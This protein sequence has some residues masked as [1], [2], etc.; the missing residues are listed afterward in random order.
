[1]ALPGEQVAIE[2]RLLRAAEFAGEDDP[3]FTIAQRM[4]SQGVSA[5]AVAVMR[6]GETHWQGFYGADSGGP[7]TLFQAAS[8][9]KAVASVGIAALAR[10]RGFSLDADIMPALAGLLDP[11]AVNPGGVKVTLRG[12]LSHTNG[13]SVSG[14]PGYAEGETVPTTLGVVLG[15]GGS[16]TGPVIIDPAQIG[17]FNYS[18]GGYTLAQ[19]WAETVS[20]ESFAALM[21]RLV[22]RPIG[23]AH[24]S[25]ALQPPAADV[26]R[27]Q[28]G[29]DGP[30]PGGWNSYPE[31]AAAGL[32]TTPA[33]YGRFAHALMRA[34]KGDGSAGI[35]PAVAA[36]VLR[37]VEDDYGLGVSVVDV[38]GKGELRFSHSGG[39]RGYRTQFNAY[40][41]RDEAIVV[42]TNAPGGWTVLGDIMRTAMRAYGWPHEPR[43]VKTRFALSGD[44]LARLAGDYVEQG[45][46]EVAVSF[47]VDGADLIGR[48]PNGYTFRMV[49][50][51]PERFVDPDEGGEITIR[52][53]EGRTVMDSYGSI[54]VKS[55]E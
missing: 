1:M 28:D 52:R 55:D 38:G 35:D 49:P 32:W 25:F 19:L 20:G 40:P 36:E 4:A 42:L 13:A 23:M 8:M 16:N 48:T 6:G 30:V 15:A 18:G 31:S 47:S 9:S 7:D 53:E 45:K 29:F 34:A 5:V 17:T 54:F 39:N 51:G 44:A 43:E 11:R 22:L 10:E 24:S 46:A 33:D 41:A 37:V 26:A 14:F 3:A 21:D 27:A 2:T 50:V 12:L